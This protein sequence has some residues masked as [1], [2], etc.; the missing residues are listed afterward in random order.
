MNK[1]EILRQGLF[2][3]N[4]VFVLLLGMCP[5]LGVTTTLQNAIGMG[6][7]VLFVLL[8]FWILLQGFHKYVFSF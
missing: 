7:S 3:E 2:T 4:P 8:F 5:T 1:K 6:L